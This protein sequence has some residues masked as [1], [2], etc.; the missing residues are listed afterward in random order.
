MIKN[1]LDKMRSPKAI[2]RLAF[3]A[4]DFL[5]RV[6]GVASIRDHF[7]A[8]P[9]LETTM[10]DPSNINNRGSTESIE[11][12]SGGSW[13]VAKYEVNSDSDTSSPTS[14]TPPVTRTQADPNVNLST[15]GSVLPLPSAHD[16]DVK[17]KD[18]DDTDE[19]TSD[20]DVEVI[21]EKP[22]SAKNL[23]HKRSTFFVAEDVEEKPQRKRVKNQQRTLTNLW[24]G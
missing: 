14:I 6:K 12:P 1:N 10:R 3:V 23:A 17:L 18:A 8:T 5:T 4:L 24:F 16:A 19:E 20:N 11:S 21:M 7:G 15:E 9:A 22:G 2:N 13:D